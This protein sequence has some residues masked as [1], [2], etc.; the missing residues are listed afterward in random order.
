MSSEQQGFVFSVTFIIIFSLLLS[1]IPA[2]L[3]GPGLTPDMLTPVNPNLVADFSESVDFVRSDFTG[4]NYFYD[5]GG[6]SWICMADDTFFF[7]WAKVLIGGI[8]WLGGTDACKFVFEG[9][10]RGE[11]LTFAEIQADADD[12]TVRY[13]LEYVLNGNSAGGFILYWNTTL[14]ANASSA[15]LADGLYLLH[16]VGIENTAS[17][18][19]GMLL[20]SLLLL[21]LPEVPL[22][23]NVL[24]AVPIW[25]GIVYIIW[26]IIKE[27][28]PFV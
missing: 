27:M 20:I 10:D 16:G 5:L 18:N 25:A 24:I 28:I 1:T 12:G 26:F 8:L 7:L 13:S 14:Y 22:L 6:R 17:M 4:V 19:I 11:S 23:V 21:Q 9:E 15:W 2:G 3:Q